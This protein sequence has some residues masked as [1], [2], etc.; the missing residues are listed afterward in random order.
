MKVIK[1][2]AIV[3]A[4]MDMGESDRIITFLSL[5]HGKIKAVAKGAKR[6][7]KRFLNALEPCTLL[8]ITVVP[9]RRSGGGLGRLDSADIRESYPAIRA[10]VNNFMLA[11][12]CCELSHMW[13]PEGDVHRDIF[14]LFQWYLDNL[15]ACSSPVMITLVFKTRLLTLAGYGQQWD[16]CVK[17]GGIPRGRKVRFSIRAGG[18]ICSRCCQPGHSEHI[19]SAGTLRS[20]AF[21]AS[22]DLSAMNRFR[23]GKTAVEEAWRI[24]GLLHCHHLQ[25]SPLSYSV[26]GNVLE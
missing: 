26:L 14:E 24:L 9:S 6:S 10:S 1:D 12:L 19:L 17:C 8:D 4:G 25:R 7:R 23:M 21:M 11:C 13:V 5:R 2:S 15:A 18:Y 20:L 16:R 22:S 3:V